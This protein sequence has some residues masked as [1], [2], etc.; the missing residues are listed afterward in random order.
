MN[1]PRLAQWLD[2]SGACDKLSDLRATPQLLYEAIHP[3][4]ALS[5]LVTEVAQAL[6][7]LSHFLTQTSNL[8]TLNRSSY[9]LL[10]LR[11]PS[12]PQTVRLNHTFQQIGCHLA[13]SVPGGG[14]RGGGAAGLQCCS[15]MLSHPLVHSL[16]RSPQQQLESFII[17]LTESTCHQPCFSD[18]NCR[19]FFTD[20]IEAFN[21]YTQ[22]LPGYP[23]LSSDKI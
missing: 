14:G 15:A 21:L 13:F 6:Q 10:L 9:L 7:F 3:P 20:K 2:P 4:N 12:L 16:C 23:L 11:V 5:S 17:P 1:R 22:C 8:S 19:S 18:D